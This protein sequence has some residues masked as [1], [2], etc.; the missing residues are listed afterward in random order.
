MM[1][2]CRKTVRFFDKLEDKVRHRLSHRPII[3][4]ILGG[5]G[6]VLFWRG[7]W[8]TADEFFPWLNGPASVLVGGILLLLSGLFVSILIGDQII[9]SGLKGERKVAEKT[10]EEIAAEESVLVRIERE[11]HQLSKEVEEVKRLVEKK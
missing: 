11:V 5:V 10:E 7:I 1:K 2:L 3:Y 4:A 8:H 6:I 9:I